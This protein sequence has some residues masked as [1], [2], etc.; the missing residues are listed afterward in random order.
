MF[1]RAAT[2]KASPYEPS[3]LGIKAHRNP[4]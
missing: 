3:K 4:L 1:H 2:T